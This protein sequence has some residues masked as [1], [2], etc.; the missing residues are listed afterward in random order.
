MPLPF[1]QGLYMLPLLS[2]ST[3]HA[4][5]CQH[6]QS[7]VTHKV[8]TNDQCRAARAILSLSQEDLS[9]AAK[10]ARRTLM[11]FETGARTPHP[12]TVDA[13]QE[14]LKAAGVEF[15]AKNGGGAG[16]RLIADF[17]RIREDGSEDVLFEFPLSKEYEGADDPPSLAVRAGAEFFRTIEPAASSRADYIRIFRHKTRAVLA[18]A[19]E[20]WRR[21]EPRG[22]DGF[23]L[24]LPHLGENASPRTAGDLG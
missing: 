23:M 24:L 5:I 12:R 9:R 1:A 20:A 22:S 15:I 14:A 3:Q 13:I 16:V 6:S 7:K 21:G 17:P 18:A 4:P 19:I 2:K 11:D 10:V 8:I